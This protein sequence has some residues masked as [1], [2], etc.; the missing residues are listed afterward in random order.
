MSDTPAPLGGAG[1][2]TPISA[3]PAAVRTV[4]VSWAAEALGRLLPVQVPAG[5][6][7]VARFTPVK[8]ARLGAAALAQAVD[9][10]PGFRAAVA[11]HARSLARSDDV[12][13]AEAAAVAHLLKLPT[14]QELMAAMER[15]APEGLRAE[16]AELKRSVRSLQ[17]DL[18]Q[19]TTERDE[20][21]LL[22]QPGSNSA[23]E[24]D[25]LRRRLREQGTRLRQAVL[26]Q[27]TEAAKSHDELV[28]LR[29]QVKRLTDEVTI[30]QD[31]TRSAV[32][33]AD[34]AQESLGRVREQAGLH[35]STADRRLDLLLSTVEGAVSGLRREW[36]LAGGGSDPADVVAGRLP[37]S[38]REAESTADP[39][40][41]H[42]WLGLPAAH[43]IVDGYNVSKTGYPGLTLAQQRERLVRVLAAL[44]ARTGV[45]VTIVF[46]GAAV[47]VPAP[48]GRGIRVLFSPP[49]VIA[50]DVIRDLVAAE[51]S[52]RVVV[53]VSSDREVADG[54]RRRGARTAGSDVLLALLG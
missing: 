42:S 29:G 6:V 43:L 54:V 24:A 38:G 1:D 21:R 51:P 10:D 28:S 30:L 13:D 5:L 7:R 37:R 23:D 2:P 39:S 45:D 27:E 40:R 50:D 11:E 22:G 8:R 33:R 44:S 49:G 19:V 48:P 41:L 18:Q 25:K 36:D 16:V 14:E 3:L 35:K 34:R 32:E 20:A 31:R 53:V 26:A 4:I 9:A 46:D 15:S 12:A 52:G 47:A 17:R